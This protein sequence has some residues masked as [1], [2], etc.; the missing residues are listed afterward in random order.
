MVE[1]VRLVVVLAFTAIGYSWGKELSATLDSVRIILGAILGAATGYVVGGILGRSIEKVVAGLERRVAE[2][3]GAD[4]VAGGIGMIGA[5]FAA[6]LVLWPLLFLPIR[7]VG[8]STLGL[9]IVVSGYVGFRSG[10]AKRE[11]MLQLFGL[12]WRT[13]AGD[14]RIMDSSAI[15]DPRLLDCVRAGFLRGPMIVPQF[16]LEEVQAI[17]D[18]GDAVRRARGRRGL[19]TLTALR[20]DRMVELRVMADRAFP[21]FAEV[22]AKVIALARERGGAIV[23]NDTAMARIA[24]LQG[25]EVLSL[26]AL[27]EALRPP[28]LPGEEIAVRLQKDGRE[29]GQGVGYLEDGTMVVVED[30]RA[31]IGRDV[32]ATVTSILQTSGGRMIFARRLTEAQTDTA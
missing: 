4:I 30:G 8:V 17:A 26:N 10:V 3:N 32:R 5:A 20:R 23:T 1:L 28:V 2:V 6:G 31:L 7:V 25:I 22:D 21:E 9:A 19:E 14:L 11:D 29:P 13:R 18:S 24:E 16:V 12:S 27:A 15:L